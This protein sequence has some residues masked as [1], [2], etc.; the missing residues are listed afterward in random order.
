MNSKET[1]SDASCN[2]SYEEEN[3][4]N[5]SYSETSQLSAQPELEATV[6]EEPPIRVRDMI[7]LYN[8]ATQKNQELAHAKSI[9]FGGNLKSATSMELRDLELA[10]QQQ[11]EQ[12][13]CDGIC[14]KI[15]TMD[16]MGHASSNS[17]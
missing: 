17:R 16:G 3:G 6:R 15:P 8:F 14:L 2:Q 10:Q 4:C 11:A 7:N 12:E 13:F 1:K 5:N 9:Y